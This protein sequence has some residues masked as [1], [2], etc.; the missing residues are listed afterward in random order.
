M[1]KLTMLYQLVLLLSWMVDLAHVEEWSDL[2]G[3]LYHTEVEAVAPKREV[4]T[5]ILERCV[6]AAVSAIKGAMSIV[7]RLVR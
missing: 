1:E 3:S 6:R 5:S 7:R 2:G 4:F